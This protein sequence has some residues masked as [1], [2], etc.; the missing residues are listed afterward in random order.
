MSQSPRLGGVKRTQ[1]EIK[2][3]EL[4]ALISDPKYI[5]RKNIPK[6]LEILNANP[7]E[8]DIN[9]R[10]IETTSGQN[11]TFLMQVLEIINNT[12]DGRKQLMEIA[13]KLIELDTS[14]ETL[15][16]VDSYFFTTPLIFACYN[17]IDKIASEL[18]KRGQVCN[19]AYQEEIK[20]TTVE[21]GCTALMYSVD[22]DT[23]FEF[24]VRLLID[25]LVSMGE[26]GTNSIGV[27][28][29]KGDT[30]LMIACRENK[31]EEGIML[32][33]IRTGHSNP[34]YVNEKYNDPLL[35]NPTAFIIAINNQ[36]YEVALELFKLGDESNIGHI[37]GTE[38]FYNG[39]PYFGFTA[40][41]LVLRDILDDD[42][43]ATNEQSELLFLFVK[44]FYNRYLQET[45]KTGGEAIDEYIVDLYF[46][47]VIICHED[48][49][50][51]KLLIEKYNTTLEGQQMLK[52]FNDAYENEA[53]HSDVMAYAQLGPSAIPTQTTLDRPKKV[54]MKY[55]TNE[56]ETGH[57]T[58]SR[59]PSRRPVRV[60]TADEMAASNTGRSVRRTATTG[61]PIADE[62]PL[63]DA[64]AA[65][66]S[67]DDFGMDPR[68]LQYG[69]RYYLAVGRKPPGGQ[70]VY[71]TGVPGGYVRF[72]S[73]S[74]SPSPSDRDS[75]AVAG[76]G[77]VS[78][79]GGV[80]YRPDPP[81]NPTG[82]KKKRKS[83]KKR[84]FTRIRKSKSKRNSKRNR[85]TKRK[86]VLNR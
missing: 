8:I 39:G 53:K 10:S 36:L 14:G 66:P 51:K 25:L 81:P 32:R 7:L 80:P 37:I 74:P 46:R 49:Y 18:I 77:P 11:R 4:F 82:G 34:G 70:A 20:D 24:R 83:R 69:P 84:K 59:S 12:V 38:I 65:S 52:A 50:I 27:V 26:P 85:N 57:I 48:E 22:K 9:Y 3:E 68:Q 42:G 62:I 19:P 75:G 79:P 55:E 86:Y 13:L 72:P 41:D 47:Y 56:G 2:G 35:K 1:T 67:L 33:I 28:N 30:A 17:S 63:A 31:I 6:I 44:Y 45:Q 5:D 71:D 40:F 54:Q 64:R 78:L 43:L 21:S 23:F 15:G 76:G 16:Q 58:F 29:S 73:P 60:Y 61:Y